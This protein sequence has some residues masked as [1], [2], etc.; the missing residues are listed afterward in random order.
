MKF[1]LFLFLYPFSCLFGLILRVRH[2]LYD[3][4]WIEVYNP[5]TLTVCVG[6][7]RVGGTGKT[8][9]VE[10]FI[11]YFF[12]K[13]YNVALLSRGY[14]RKTKGYIEVLDF[15][16]A[17]KVGDE[18]LQ[19]KKKFPN[20]VVCVCENRKKGIDII[21]KQFSPDVILLDDAMQH[22]KVKATKTVLLTTYS[23]PYFQDYLLPCGRLRDVRS[24]SK[25]ADYVIVTKT[26]NN[27]SK[28]N[29]TAFQRKIKLQPHQSLLFSSYKYL[30]PKNLL[31]EDVDWEKISTAIV[32][33]AIA[34]PHLFVEEV[35]KNCIIMQTMTFADHH[36]F[37]IQEVKMFVN[38]LT[39]HQDLYLITTEK[40]AQRVLSHTLDCDIKKRMIYL[41]IEVII[42]N[43][44]YI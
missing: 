12:Q 26:P 5:K 37:S 13:N 40:D 44:F 35:R 43:G 42:E 2:C 19:I 8:P 24:R 36:S 7:L 17:E 21:E 27:I 38:L 9:H 34:E 15:D 32:V 16:T 23:D 1:F 20:I 3:K 14:G 10:Y 6:N 18:P 4:R 31:N 41:P 11:R 28:E 29:K 33:S 22:R 39:Q 30:P 25:A